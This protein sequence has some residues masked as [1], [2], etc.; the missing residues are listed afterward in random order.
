M[1]LKHFIRC[2][3]LCHVEGLVGDEDDDVDAGVA[4]GGLGGAQVAQREVVGT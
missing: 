4:G 3:D 2:L 1:L